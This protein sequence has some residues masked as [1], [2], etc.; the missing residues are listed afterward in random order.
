MSIE[1]GLTCPEVE[2]METMEENKMEKINEAALEEIEKIFEKFEKETKDNKRTGYCNRDNHYECEEITKI[3]CRIAENIKCKDEQ[4]YMDLN[5]RLLEL[6][7]KAVSYDEN[8][9]ISHSYPEFAKP[10]KKL[11]IAVVNNH[12]QL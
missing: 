4:E 9:G 8:R 6:H 7:T 3:L 10:I 11:I 1:N 2:I 5:A 12:T